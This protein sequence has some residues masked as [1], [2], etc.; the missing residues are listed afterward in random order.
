MSDNIVDIFL[1]WIGRPPE[2]FICCP[3]CHHRFNDWFVTRVYKQNPQMPLIPQYQESRYCFL[4][5]GHGKD[6]GLILESEGVQLTKRQM[7]EKQ[8]R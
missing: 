8:T 1:S 6:N 5:R 2:T 7:I 3:R 4:C